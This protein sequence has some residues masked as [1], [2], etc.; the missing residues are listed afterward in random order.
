[1]EV[2]KTENA[3]AAIGPYSQGVKVGNL[4]FFSGQIPLRPDGTM[5][6]GDIL[7]QIT[8]VLENLSALLKVAGGSFDNVVKSTMFLIDLADFQVANETYAKYF[9]GEKKPAR[10]TIQVAALPKGAQVEIEC[11]VYVP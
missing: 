7:A 2:I 8:Q 9:S 10:S 5:V 3:P 11:V 6:E 4:V 1:M